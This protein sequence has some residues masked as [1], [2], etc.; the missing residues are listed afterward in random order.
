MKFLRV[1]EIAIS[2]HNSVIKEIWNPDLEKIDT[3]INSK[4]HQ[5]SKISFKDC[6]IWHK[7]MLFIEI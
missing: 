7:K 4:L 6:T 1:T 3:L 2:L 5:L